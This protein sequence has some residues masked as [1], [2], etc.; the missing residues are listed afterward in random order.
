LSAPELYPAVD[1]LGGRAVRLVQGDFS[2]K[3]EYAADP[4]DA[5]ARWVAEGARWLHVVDLDGA[6]AGRPANLHNLKRMA[7]ELDVPIEYGGGLRDSGSA[8]KALEI[9]AQ[10]VVIGT[11]A[12]AVPSMLDQ[13]LADDPDRLAVA[14]DVRGGRISTGGWAEVTDLEPHTSVEQLAARGVG[15]FVYTDVDRDG[16]LDG[17]AADAFV[18]VCT[19]AGERRVIYSGGIGTIDHLR[20]LAA[21]DISNLEGVIVGKALY[22][23]RFSVAEGRAALGAEA[24]A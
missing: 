23:G 3:T 14:I 1:I 24:T 4:L 10:R 8:R 7:A 17:V 13:L 19:A 11:A 15:C 12:F 21:L 22:E 6:R 18:R 16:T 5:G 20:A 2:R 9:G